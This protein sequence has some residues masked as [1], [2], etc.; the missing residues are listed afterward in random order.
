[1]VDTGIGIKPKIIA[2]LGEKAYETH[3][4]QGL[5]N[6]GI[7]LGLFICKKVI[8]QLGPNNT[9]TVKSVPNTKTQFIFDIFF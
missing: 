6:K 7:G 9:F 1:M 3:N 2:K 8:Q 4:T 5:N